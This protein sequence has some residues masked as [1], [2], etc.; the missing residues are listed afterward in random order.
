M[1]QADPIGPR[2]FQVEP[3]SWLGG[4]QGHRGA[5]LQVEAARSRKHIRLQSFPGGRG[6][7]TPPPTRDPDFSPVTPSCFPAL[8]NRT[9]HL[10]GFELWQDQETKTK[11]DPLPQSPGLRLSPPLQPLCLLTSPRS[12]S[13][14]SFSESHVP[15][16]HHMLINLLTVFFFFF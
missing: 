10:G 5:P 4:P 6:G 16:F 13:Q 14:S 3:F 12:P 8:G 1:L 9:I 2:S 11:S 15:S 7:D